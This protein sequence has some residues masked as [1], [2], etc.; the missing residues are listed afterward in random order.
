MLF[1]SMLRPVPHPYQANVPSAACRW[2][3]T[4]AAPLKELRLLSGRLLSVSSAAPVRREHLIHGCAPCLAAAAAAA[5]QCRLDACALLLLPL[6]PSALL[7]RR[8]C[9]GGRRG[10]RVRINLI[11]NDSL[12]SVSLLTYLQV[13]DGWLVEH[14]C[15]TVVLLYCTGRNLGC[16]SQCR[17][18]AGHRG[19]FVS[20]SDADG[21][22]CRPRTPLSFRRMRCASTWNRSSTRVPPGCLAEP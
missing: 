14:V 4:S 13:C 21:Q 5:R 3:W 15:T 7:R 9:V 22:S 19:L 18:A 17:L 20:S 6:Q 2:G 16:T 10:W 12:L 1:D 11:V 8:R